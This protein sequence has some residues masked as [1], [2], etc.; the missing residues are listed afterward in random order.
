MTRAARSLAQAAVC[1]L[2]VPFR[3]H[4]R[5]PSTGLDCIGLV[6]A[7]IEGSGRSPSPPDHY[8]LR[9][10]DITNALMCTKKS[11]LRDVRGP[12][13]PDDIVLVRPAPAQFHLL[14]AENA[15][16]FIHAHAGL[17]RIVRMPGPL[18]WTIERHWRLSLK[19]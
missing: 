19:D 17:R 1:F 18:P 8:A 5:D 4:G 3:L 16:S 7:A 6:A 12:I 13:L 15:N 11:G 14:I 9:N 2:D 10:L